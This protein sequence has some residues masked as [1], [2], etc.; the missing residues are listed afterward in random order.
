MNGLRK[1]QSVNGFH[2]HQNSHHGQRN[3]P[4]YLPEVLHALTTLRDEDAETIAT[5]TTTNA[6]EL[7]KLT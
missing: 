5:Q 7:L 2:A 4:E 6:I 3:S 1:Q